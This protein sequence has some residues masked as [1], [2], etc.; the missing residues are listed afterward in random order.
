[1][2][3]EATMNFDPC[4]AF[5]EK[6]LDNVTL[7]NHLSFWF[8][9]EPVE[10]SACTSCRRCKNCAKFSRAQIMDVLSLFM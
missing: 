8:L 6:K 9:A 4:V 7:F 1:M 10:W 5:L 3:R 2:F